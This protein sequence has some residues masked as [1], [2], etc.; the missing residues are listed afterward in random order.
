MTKPPYDPWTTL[1]LIL[2]EEEL[3]RL[4]RRVDLVLK[5]DPAGYVLCEALTN[6][7]LVRE[8]ATQV[9]PPALR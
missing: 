5:D 7:I 4:R 6:E 1:M 2:Y 9:Q 8:L 3:L